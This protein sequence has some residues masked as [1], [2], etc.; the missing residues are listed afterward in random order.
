MV[1]DQGLSPAETRWPLH[2]HEHKKVLAYESVISTDYYPMGVQ[3]RFDDAKGWKNLP[4]CDE[5]LEMKG[6]MHFKE[7]IEPLNDHTWYGLAW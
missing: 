3:G 4:D 2:G 5:P 6:K 1:M 7:S